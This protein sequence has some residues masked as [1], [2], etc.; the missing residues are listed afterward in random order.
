[1]DEFD[2]SGLTIAQGD[3]ITEWLCQPVVVDDLSWGLDT[4]ALRLRAAGRDYIVKAGG[5][6]NHHIG[7]EIAAFG[8][9]GSI[10]ADR[11][12]GSRLVAADRD[13]NLLLLEHLEGTLV[14]GTELE[15]AILRAYPAPR[16]I[17]VPTHGD[18]QPRNW[19]IEDALARF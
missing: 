16:V 13:A 3:R 2:G 5:A 10:L 6:A 7:R 1:M 8:T 15:L 9:F 17:T 12:V 11:S 4:T 18:W 14:E 19:L